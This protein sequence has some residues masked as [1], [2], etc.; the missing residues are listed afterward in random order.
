[1]CTGKAGFTRQDSKER[2][3][4]FVL[5]VVLSV[6][7]LFSNY[8]ATLSAC[9]LHNGNLLT[10]QDLSAMSR[11]PVLCCRAAAA[12]TKGKCTLQAGFIIMIIIYIKKSTVPNYNIII[13]SCR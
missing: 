4:S 6:V 11:F 3:L 7:Y 10:T 2:T 5:I 13:H 9:P 1:M 12:F 8:C